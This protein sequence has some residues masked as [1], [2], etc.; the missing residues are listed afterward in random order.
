LQT[1]KQVDPF[2]RSDIQEIPYT[3]VASEEKQQDVE[4]NHKE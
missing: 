4:N 2:K 3:E 1:K